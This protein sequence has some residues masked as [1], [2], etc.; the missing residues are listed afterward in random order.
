MLVGEG[1][2]Q[3]APTLIVGIGP[4]GRRL[5]RFVT[6]RQSNARLRQAGLLASL[7]EGELEQIEAV[8]E[9]LTRHQAVV[10][11]EIGLGLRAP[12]D[13]FLRL[14]LVTAFSADEVAEFGLSGA[15]E[16]LI[17]RFLDYPHPP[18]GVR[19][20]IAV[21][22]SGGHLASPARGI[23]SLLTSVSDLLSN[24]P[25]ANSSAVL[26]AHR[27]LFG[28]THLNHDGL[29][30]LGRTEPDE[31]EIAL[32]R[33]V[34]AH[35]HPQSE[36]R[37]LDA[38]G[39]E[40]YVAG[41]ASAVFPRELLLHSA[42][43][44]VGAD[45]LEELLGEIGEVHAKPLAPLREDLFRSLAAKVQG[46]VGP[47]TRSTDPIPRRSWFSRWFDREVRPNLTPGVRLEPK[48]PENVYHLDLSALAEQ[49]E[50]I[51]EERVRSVVKDLA[52]LLPK[53]AQ[54][55]AED[56]ADS[57]RR[58]IDDLV[59][60]T[61]GGVHA[62]E[63]AVIEAKAS[64][65]QELTAEESNLARKAGLAANGTRGLSPRYVPRRS[66]EF[67][68]DT[69]KLLARFRKGIRRLP[70]LQALAVRAM[71][72][73]ATWYPIGAALAWGP[74]GGT[75]VLGAT[76]AVFAVAWAVQR[77]R[78][79]RMRGELIFRLQD[80]VGRRAYDLIQERLGASSVKD[81]SGQ[82]VVVLG[83]LPQLARY[84]E[85]WEAPLLQGFD[86]LCGTGVR[87]LRQSRHWPNGYT[88]GLDWVESDDPRSL[89]GQVAYKEAA[90]AEHAKRLLLEGLFGSWRNPSF[91]E[92]ES[93]LRQDA[94]EYALDGWHTRTLG[95]FF[96]Q[97]RTSEK[98]NQKAVA[99]AVVQRLEALGASSQPLAPNVDEHA[100]GLPRYL[101]IRVPESLRWLVAW[102]EAT[103]A[104][105]AGPCPPG[106]RLV[107]LVQW[108]MPGEVPRVE[109][110]ERDF[111][112]VVLKL[113]APNVETALKW[114]G[115]ATPGSTT[116]RPRKALLVAQAQY[117]DNPLPSTVQEVA[118]LRACLEDLGF[119]VTGL[120]DRTARQ[121]QSAVS[122]YVNDLPDRAISFFVFA[123]HGSERDGA[124]ML[125]GIDGKSY[126]LDHFF[127]KL[128]ER[129]SLNVFV[130]DCC[131]VVYAG[132]SAKPNRAP[133]PPNSIA[134]FA[135]TEAT[136]AYS[137]TF[138][139]EFVQAL[140]EPGLPIEDVLRRARLAVI[141]KSK[142]E[143]VPTEE[144]SL[145]ERLVLRPGGGP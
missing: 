6:E 100:G 77:L 134:V 42:A 35:L 30:D 116:D 15:V 131:R 112:D 121:I 3:A 105:G 104:Q 102:Q 101:D 61:L 55:L 93:A 23:Q 136:H 14:R 18:E 8:I 7:S 66:E 53:S 78:L 10:K 111:A 59:A 126:N 25:S 81:A 140:R 119:E 56:T 99:V 29:L 79:E 85:T 83:V 129:G 97:L 117:A 26:L 49:F 108:L 76:L 4:A 144:S 109:S 84:L 54:K 47:V 130:L 5:A 51:V 58:A 36:Y 20:V 139:P 50:G 33:L 96:R 110:Q 13:R 41:G 73:G 142:G 113:V 95:E 12:F 107:G 16:T 125:A 48:L 43:Q 86:N 68:E 64:V 114:V 34:E 71:I 39:V 122:K 24:A 62:A 87:L 63:R 88:P 92:I 103:G 1:L 115:G 11:A 145:T 98:L 27:R 94:N 120:E 91:P 138:L 38:G 40:Y 135:T 28:G 21:D 45:V 60:K 141:D 74:I 22:A 57:I 137:T 72:C 133:L 65:L 67:P 31:F 52:Q 44:Q 46:T 80:E 17:R 70:A 69:D 123:G 132:G 75:V 106:S 128:K 2:P 90:R 127:D 82:P 37:A 9:Q 124:S 32:G 89:H 19:T 143:Q 118:E